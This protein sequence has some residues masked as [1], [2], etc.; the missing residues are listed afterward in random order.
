MCFLI[1]VC[2]SAVGGKLGQQGGGNKEEGGGGG[3]DGG[4]A[5]IGFIVVDNSDILKYHHD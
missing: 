2:V 1:K 5:D 3:G 4:G